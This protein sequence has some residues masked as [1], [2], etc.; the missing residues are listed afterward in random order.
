MKFIFTILIGLV[1]FLGKGQ[2]D[3]WDNY[4]MSVNNK[5]VSIVVNLGLKDVA[6]SKE[7]PY[8]IILRLTYPEMDEKGFPTV[9]MADDLNKL[10]SAL[11]ASLLRNNGAWYAGRFTQRGLREFYFYAL[12]TVGYLRA[13]A[14]VLS[15]YPK[16]PWLVKAVY[17]KGWTNYFEVLYPRDEEREK[18]ENRKIIDELVRKGDATDRSRPIDHTLF[19][20]SDWHRKEFL[21]QLDEPGFK[22]IDMP[23]ERSQNTEMGFKL[24]LRR[25]DK[26]EIYFMNALTIRLS[27]L[28]AKHGGKYDGWSTYVVRG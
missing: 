14:M 22:V 13:C 3:Q 23:V 4:V 24:V 12:D 19:F 18:M 9:E 1:P 26:P 11:E 15:Q 25:D 21:K 6:P 28:A 8:A 2:A 27:Q 20:K 10:E 17:D 16:F 5:P 7:R